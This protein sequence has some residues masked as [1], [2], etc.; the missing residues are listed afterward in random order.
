MQPGSGGM[1][2]SPYA[3]SQGYAQQQQQV[4]R[5]GGD[6]RLSMGGDANAMQSRA[7]EVERNFYDD[8]YR[9][10][11]RELIGDV[12]SSRLIDSAKSNANKG[13]DSGQTRGLRQRQRRGVNATALDSSRQ[14]VTQQQ[15]Q[16]LN[17]D[18]QVNNSRIAQVERND[19]LRSEMVN[20]S[21]DLAS[22]ATTGLGAAAQNAT[23]R[24]NTNNSIDAQNDAAKK[25]TQ[26]QVAGMA[27]MALMM[28]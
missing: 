23:Q 17:Y 10:V 15:G 19:G 22:Q 21:R 25:Q 1:R 27:M 3:M 8:L 18:T 4:G 13:Y 12:N 6:Y 16:G 9:P 28:M 20:L 14:R 7:A 26:G 24:E 5:D 11:N 2:Q